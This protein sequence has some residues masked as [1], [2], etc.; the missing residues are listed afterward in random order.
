MGKCQILYLERKSP[1]TSTDWRLTNWKTDWQKVSGVL[2]D[3]KL[4]VSHLCVLGTKQDL[5]CIRQSGASRLR[6]GCQL[7]K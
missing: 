4:M 6:D 3:T 7:F 2:I 1:S 5:G